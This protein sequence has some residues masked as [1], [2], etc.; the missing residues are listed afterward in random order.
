MET[1]NKL[2]RVGWCVALVATLGGLTISVGVASAGKP[3]GGGGAVPAG[4]IYYVLGSPSVDASARGMNPDGTNKT[5]FANRTRGT[6]SRLTHGGKRWFLHHERLTAEPTNWAPAGRVE[7]FAVREDGAVRVRLTNDPAMD[8]FHGSFD[9][10]PDE[11]A[12]DVLVNG[13]ARRWSADGATVVPGS[14]GV[15]G[16]RLRFD[17]AGNVIGLDA[18][19]A[20][21]VAVG[22]TYAY[23]GQELADADIYSWSPDLTRIVADHLSFGTASPDL[24]VIDVSTGVATTLVQAAPGGSVD[25]PDWSP[26]GSRIAFESADGRGT[27]AIEVVSPTGGG[28]AIVTKQR[29]GPSLNEPKWSP[30]SAH[31]A[32][33]S[34]VNTSPYAVDVW[35]VSA[36]GSGAT[37]LT[38]DTSANAYVLAWR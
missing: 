23:Y 9:W 29:S 17:E 2:S 24:R 33:D 31:L 16:A 5:Q 10:A 15:Y 30:D 38:T 21:L 11:S 19:P 12:S 27:E 36:S 1:R 28:R 13:L 20:F 4:T 22:V 18:Q 26:D 14:S 32:Y 25:N 8:Y 6:A 37:N 3:S 35:R 7:I 34:M